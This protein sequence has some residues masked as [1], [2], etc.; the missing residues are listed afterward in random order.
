MLY[1]F[2]C[3][4]CK[5]NKLAYQKYAISQANVTIQPE[6]HIEY[7]VF[8]I[9]ET[10]ELDCWN[11]YVCLRC[12]QELQPF[13]VNIHTDR[14]LIKYLRLSPQE[15]QRREEAYEERLEKHRR[16][17]EGTSIEEA[18]GLILEFNKNNTLD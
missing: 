7:G 16:E 6:E 8:R 18:A 4:R 3:K 17:L 11:S 1:D 14:D 12:G 5:S 13:G 2:E 15:R 9:H 10:A